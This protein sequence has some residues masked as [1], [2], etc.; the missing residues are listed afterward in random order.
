MT[1]KSG[2]LRA[3]LHHRIHS[4]VTQWI[5]NI[6]GDGNAHGM[7][8]FSLWRSLC[9]QL[10]ILVLSYLDYAAIYAWCYLI[11][12]FLGLDIKFSHHYLTLFSTSHSYECFGDYFLSSPS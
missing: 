7:L 12:D 6:E 2:L 4:C 9:S 8:N 11:T 3:L 1:K 5:G 10:T